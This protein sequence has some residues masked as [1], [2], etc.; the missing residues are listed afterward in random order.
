MT[1]K[2]EDVLVLILLVV[3]LL[4]FPMLASYHRPSAL[5]LFVGV[6][7]CAVAFYLRSSVEE[8][9]RMDFFPW[10]EANLVKKRDRDSTVIDC[11]WYLDQDKKK[12]Y[13]NNLFRLSDPVVAGYSDLSS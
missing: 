2:K 12:P 10:N 9:N 8:Y 7:V 13:N 4:L 5:F 6:F 3:P 11:A 1:D